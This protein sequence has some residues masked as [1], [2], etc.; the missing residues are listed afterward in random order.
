M[1]KIAICVPTYNEV[2]TIEAIVKKIDVGLLK[3]VKNYQ[4]Y[5]VNCDNNSKD[6]TGEKFKQINTRNS[7]KVYI[8]SNE[9]GKGINLINFFKFCYEKNINYAITLDADVI[10][11]ENWWIEAFLEMLINSRVDYVVPSYK[12]NRFEGTTTNLFAFPLIYA[13]TGVKIRQPI[14]GDFAFNRK[15]IEHILKQNVNDE[16]KR[17]GIDIFMTLN[18]IYG[19]FKIKT[20]ELGQKI[21]KPS[22]K[23]MYNMFGEVLKSAIFTIENQKDVIIKGIVENLDTKDINLIKSRNYI[24]K[25]EANELL[26]TSYNAVKN[27]ANTYSKRLGYRGKKIILDSEWENIMINIIRDLIIK[28]KFTEE[29]TKIIQNLFIIRAVSYW[30]KVEKMSAMNSEKIILTVANNLR[31]KLTN[32]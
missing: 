15:Y 20:I 32:N 27:S 28:R 18:A 3:Y 2:D 21:H 24:H 6:G 8:G 25:I 11:M 5:I 7:E 31:N 1:E 30:N 16:I 14:G 23:K 13:V 4:C 10:S 29:E 12:R 9:V 19:K 17:Y 26:I 22:F